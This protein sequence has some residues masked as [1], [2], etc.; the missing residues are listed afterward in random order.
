MGK[1]NFKKVSGKQVYRKWKE[2]EIG[3]FVAG[4]FVR[5]TP[6]YKGST[7]KPNFILEVYETSFE[8]VK[9]G[10]MFCLNYN[11][12]L[13]YHMDVQKIQEGDVIKVEYEG[14]EPM[15]D[16]PETKAHQVS[17]Y[18]ADSGDMAVEEA[19]LPP[20]SEEDEDYGL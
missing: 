12:L 18:K 10:E 17:L 7:D 6:G 8:G 2:W 16:D 11:G 5:T 19:D 15:K 14:E 4:K 1:F 13:G 20:E 3:D 9:E